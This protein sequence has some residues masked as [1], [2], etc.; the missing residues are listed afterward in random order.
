MNSIKDLI[1]YLYIVREKIRAA[2]KDKLWEYSLPRVKATNEA[3]SSWE[4]QNGLV[5]PDA[6]KEFLLAANGWHN[7]FQ[8]KDLF[9]LEELSL[10]KDNRYIQCLNDCIDN[11]HD[12]GD[13]TCLLPIGGT[14]YSYDLY[15][16][17]LDR[18]S[19]FYGQVLWVAGEEV[20]RHNDFNAFFESLIAYNKYN[21][22]LLKGMPYDD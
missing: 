19:E 12:V 10:S 8:D 18:V 5:L 4:E 1:G 20:E 14:E 2:D 16:I 21:F 15:L 17:V 9:S 7:V 13:K 6:Y 3:V 22:K 11:I